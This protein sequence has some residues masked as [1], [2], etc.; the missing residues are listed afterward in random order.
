[1][2]METYTLVLSEDDDRGGIM[3]DVYNDGGTIT[4]SVFL[5]YDSYGLTPDGDGAPDDRRRE[6]TADVTTLN[7]DV[8]RDDGG[9]QFRLLGDGNRELLTER[10]GDGEWKLHDAR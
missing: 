3:G 1:M 7:L 5:D 9:F 4:E 10:V 8:A 2:P 6:T